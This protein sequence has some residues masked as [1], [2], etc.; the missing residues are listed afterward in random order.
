MKFWITSLLPAWMLGFL[1]VAAHA[2]ERVQETLR[3]NRMEVAATRDKRVLAVAGIK[4]V[5]NGQLA[6]DKESAVMVAPA[7]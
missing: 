5:F 7:K 1:P 6:L 2:A 3:K 4:A